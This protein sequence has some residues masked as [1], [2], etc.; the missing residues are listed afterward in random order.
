M[1]GLGKYDYLKQ[2]QVCQPYREGE[3]LMSKLMTVL[4][5]IGTLIGIYLFL[6][7]GKETTS[8]INTIGSN[9]ISGIKTLQGR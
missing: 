3:I 2:G 1:A 4:T 5:G 8:I 6:A 7:N 9:S